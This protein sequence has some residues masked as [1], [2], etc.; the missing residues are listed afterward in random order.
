MQKKRRYLQNKQLTVKEERVLN[1]NSSVEHF[2]K[3]P[4]ELK[5]KLQDSKLNKTFVKYNQNKSHGERDAN[6]NTSMTEQQELIQFPNQ[7]NE[8]KP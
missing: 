7:N 1:L 4:L 6:L 8:K 2:N 3:D 5:T